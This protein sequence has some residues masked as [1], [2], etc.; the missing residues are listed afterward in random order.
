MKNKNTPKNEELTD[1]DTLYALD[2][3]SDVRFLESPL[4]I[5]A[6]ILFTASF[7]MLIVVAFMILNPSEREKS[8]S[9][10]D[11]KGE[12]VLFTPEEK[13]NILYNQTNF[14]KEHI[15][16]EDED[17][18]LLR[19]YQ[20]YND[21]CIGIISIE[22]SVLNHPLMQSFDDEDYYLTHDLDKVTNS[23]GVPF[24]T[25]DS[26]LNRENGNNIVYGH[27]IR[28]SD[29]DVFADLTYYEDVEYY[30]SHPVIKLV[31]DSGT[32]YYIIFAYYLIDTDDGEFIYWDDTSWGSVASYKKYMEEVEKR[33]WLKND[34]TYCYEDQFLTL[35]TCSV[36]LAHS[37][38]NRMVVMA[39]LLYLDE[40]YTSYIENAQNRA[41]PLLPKKLRGE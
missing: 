12:E 36:E 41:N 2:N 20:A 28:T 38:T 11:D 18:N 24:L 6:V 13:V 22:D 29:R 33:N 8:V 32:R 1:F 19:K 17:M 23:H 35:S 5:I 26:D 27:N 10:E 37:G 30:K 7:I 34:V 31:T 9:I 25:L 16:I 21:E 3:K 14:E 40:D 4:G 15:E 39:R